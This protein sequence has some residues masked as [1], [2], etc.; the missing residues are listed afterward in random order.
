MV[1]KY[2]GICG[3]STAFLSTAADTDYY[4]I[5]AAWGS[6]I[7]LGSPKGRTYSLKVYSLADKFANATKVAG[8]DGKPDGLM[9]TGTTSA[10]GQVCF[11]GNSVPVPFRY[12]EYRFIVG[13][14]SANGSYSPYWP[15]WITAAK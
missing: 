10:G 3:G 5:D 11:S 15:Y 8:A 14:E 6:S 2:V 12:G 1:R 7:C 13:V 9:W 4:Q